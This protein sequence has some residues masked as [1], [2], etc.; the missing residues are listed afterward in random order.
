MEPAMSNTVKCAVLTLVL[1][2]WAAPALAQAQAMPTTQPPILVIYREVIKPGHDAAHVITESGWPEAFAKANSPDTYLAMASMTGPSE[3]WFAQPWDSFMAWGEA[4]ARDEANAELSAALQRLSMADAEHVE[5]LS[6]VEARAVPEMSYG[7]FPDL[8]QARFWEIS[9]LRVRPGHETQFAAA[10]N[11]LK[12]AA[13]RLSTDA[14][15]RVYAVTQGMPGGTFLI[16]SSVESFGDFDAKLSGGQAM[17]A[18]LT[19]AERV[20]LQTF[21]TEALI[22]AISNRFRLDPK[23]SYVSEETKDTDP[24]FWRGGR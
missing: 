8:N 1:A 18:G 5:S 2:A 21:A 15:W 11:A 19:D 13:G 10:V 20:A 22:S 16:F 24:E 7:S 6:V 9:T 23:M 17:M 4:M 14:G 3:V 12:A